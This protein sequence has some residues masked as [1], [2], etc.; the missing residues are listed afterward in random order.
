MVEKRPKKFFSSKNNNCGVGTEKTVLGSN[1]NNVKKGETKPPIVLRICRG[2]LFQ[3]LTA[4]FFCFIQ[5]SK[6]GI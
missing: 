6:L 2:K 1:V 3:S 5:S 4:I